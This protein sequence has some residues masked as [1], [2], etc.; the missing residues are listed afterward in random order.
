MDVLKRPSF[1]PITDMSVMP[2]YKT[3]KDNT[4][5]LVCACTGSNN[6]AAESAGYDDV[7]ALLMSDAQHPRVKH[8]LTRLPDESGLSDNEC[9]ILLDGLALEYRQ[10]LS[11]ADFGSDQVSN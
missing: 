9:K 2:Q 6:H 5:A 11:W 10:C 4:Y 3:L 7:Y 1:Y 8:F